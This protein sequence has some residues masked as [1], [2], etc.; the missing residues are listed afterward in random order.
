MSS[1]ALNHR[2]RTM[3][4]RMPS[5]AAITN[6]GEVCSRIDYAAMRATLMLRAAGQKLNDQSFDIPTLDETRA[7][8]ESVAEEAIAGFLGTEA[9]APAGTPREDIEG[10]ASTPL[11]EIYARGRG[12][13]AVVLEIF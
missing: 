7:Y 12:K 2:R 10:E 13:G 1:I 8:I 6:P 4:N 11:F 9:V 5:L 3:A